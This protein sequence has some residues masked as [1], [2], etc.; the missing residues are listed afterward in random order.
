MMVSPR[1]TGLA[2]ISSKRRAS[3]GRDPSSSLRMGTRLSIMHVYP[4]WGAIVLPLPKKSVKILWNFI[5]SAGAGSPV[6]T[7]T[8][9]GDC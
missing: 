9:L 7:R 2:H 5:T 4:C 6:K 8:K 1:Q 3:N